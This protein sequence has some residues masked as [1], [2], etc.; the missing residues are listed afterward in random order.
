MPTKTSLDFCFHLPSNIPG[1]VKSFSPSYSFYFSSLLKSLQI[2]GIANNVSFHNCCSC[3]FLK[4]DPIQ[5]VD[6]QMHIQF[7]WECF[8]MQ[9]FQF[10]CWHRCSNYQNFFSPLFFF[11]LPLLSSSVFNYYYFLPCN[12]QRSMKKMSSNPLPEET[13]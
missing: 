2:L 5:A 9:I 10:I 4:T 8:K 6:K 7:I 12:R 1:K 11:P 13:R 3:F